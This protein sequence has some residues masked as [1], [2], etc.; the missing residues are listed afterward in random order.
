MKKLY[1]AKEYCRDI[2]RCSPKTAERERIAGNGP[3]FVLI[4]RRIYY[5]EED[6]EEFV[7]SRVRN[8]T[9]DTRHD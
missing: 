5:R 3:P 7:A 4:G 6:I 2:R 8:S 9:S 1:T